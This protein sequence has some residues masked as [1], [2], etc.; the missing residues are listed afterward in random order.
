MTQSDGPAHQAAVVSSVPG[1]MRLRFVRSQRGLEE[2]E[3]VGEA[4]A[5]RA[6]VTDVRSSPRTGS[7]V[8]RYDAAA[9]TPADL[10]AA[11]GELGVA[12]LTDDVRSEGPPPAAGVR[13]TGAATRLNRRVGHATGGTDLRLLVPLG[14]GALS[15]RQ[16][17]RGVP[18]LRQAPWYV[19]AWYASETFLKLRDGGH[20]ELGSGD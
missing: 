1:R 19:L 16:A 5:A 6:S 11:L 13:V 15:L 12:V 3:R 14:L 2:R 8:L 17:V 7:M 18:G 9:T 20:A 10:H 4:L